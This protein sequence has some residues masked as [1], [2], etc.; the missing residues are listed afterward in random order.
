MLPQEAA[1]RPPAR[2]PVVGLPHYPPPAWG[3]WPSL[4]PRPANRAV[5]GPARPP[6]GGPW[7]AAGKPGGNRDGIPKRAAAG[8]TVPGGSM[9]Q[10]PYPGTPCTAQ[11]MRDKV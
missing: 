1:G 6:A 7:P 3:T 8:A 4:A 5:T 10:I 9:R 11:R 2:R